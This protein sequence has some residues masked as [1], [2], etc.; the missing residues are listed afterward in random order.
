MK[1]SIERKAFLKA[2]EDG[3]RAAG[4]TTLPITLCV[5]IKLSEGKLKVSSTNNKTF[6]SKQIDLDYKGEPAEFGVEANMLITTLKSIKDPMV[7]LSLENKQLIVA[8]SKGE[9]CFPV[10]DAAT[11]PRPNFDKKVREITMDA[12]F[13]TSSLIRA[14]KFVY[15]DKT[16]DRPSLQCVYCYISEGYLYMAASDNHVLF[17]DGME[18]TGDASQFPPHGILIPSASIPAIVNSVQREGEIVI[19]DRD[20][21]FSINSNDCNILV[22]KG[23]GMYPR[24]DRFF[25]VHETRATVKVTDIIESVKRCS[26]AASTAMDIH[27][28]CEHDQVRIK[29]SDMIMNKQAQDSFPCVGCLEGKSVSLSATHLSAILSALPS[30]EV[31]LCIKDSSSTVVL[32]PADFPNMKFIV[33]PLSPKQE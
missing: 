21:N 5:K 29:A 31:D 10:V 12:D 11:F 32:C 13:F 14:S 1:L 4:K 17:R 27:L 28:E 15:A 24:I 25:Q 26:I 3:G 23:E 18:Y 20:N 30:D 2:V 8:H 16:D 33:M 9:L 22:V 19:M 6:V 7:E